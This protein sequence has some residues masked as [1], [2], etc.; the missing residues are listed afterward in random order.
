MLQ[1]LNVRNEDKYNE[2][3]VMITN[4]SENNNPCERRKTADTLLGSKYDNRGLDIEM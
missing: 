1:N 2:W 3:K 4:N